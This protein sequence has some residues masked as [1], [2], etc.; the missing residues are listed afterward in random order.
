VIVALQHEDPGAFAVVLFRLNLKD[1]AHRVFAFAPRE[2]EVSLKVSDCT[3][4][5]SK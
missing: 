5:P 3:T 1:I 2:K 4:S